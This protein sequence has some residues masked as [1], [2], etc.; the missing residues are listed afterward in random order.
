MRIFLYTCVDGFVGEVL[1]GQAELFR[2]VKLPVA[3]LQVNVHFL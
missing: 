2:V 1:D 3:H